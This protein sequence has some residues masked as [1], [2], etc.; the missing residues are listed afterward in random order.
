MEEFITMV[1]EL[2]SFKNIEK[3][4]NKKSLKALLKKL[5][6]RE[7]RIQKELEVCGKT[8]KSKLLEEELELIKIHIK[9]AKKFL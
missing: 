7:E 5:E 2:F 1:K 4:S 6:K 3:K 8:K 9:K